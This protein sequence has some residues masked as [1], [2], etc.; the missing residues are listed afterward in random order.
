MHNINTPQIN[1]NPNPQIDEILDEAPSTIKN[2]KIILV[3]CKKTDASSKFE[4][5]PYCI[6]I[7]NGKRFIETPQF[8]DNFDEGDLLIRDFIRLYKVFPIKKPT[9]Q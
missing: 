5:H 4:Y 3:A 9:Y 7:F 6:G 8:Y 1:F 2:T